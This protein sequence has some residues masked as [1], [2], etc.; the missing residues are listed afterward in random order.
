MGIHR[1]LHSF[2][3]R[4]PNGEVGQL[5]ST[6]FKAVSGLIRSLKGPP[7]GV[8]SKVQTPEQFRMGIHSQLHGFH[9]RTP[10]GEVGELGSTQF[11]KVIALAQ[12]HFSQDPLVMGVGD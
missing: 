9:H 6:Q 5:G 8:I 4:T 12:V 1:Q 11:E 7:G 3:H 10:N 2:H